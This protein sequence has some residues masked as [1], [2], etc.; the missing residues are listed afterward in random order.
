MSIYKARIFKKHKKA[1]GWLSSMGDMLALMLTF[2]VLLFSISS[3][4]NQ[5]F[6]STQTISDIDEVRKIANQFNYS[7]AINFDRDK[8][9]Q[10]T[11]YIYKVLNQHTKQIPGF[12]NVQISLGKGWINISIYNSLLFHPNGDRLTPAG[13]ILLLDLIDLLDIYDNR[14]E[15]IGNVSTEAP[16]LEN[17]TSRWI[18]GLA[19]ANTIRQYLFDNGVVHN[20]PIGSRAWT[21]Q[22]QVSL[23]FSSEEREQLINRIEF[24]I[25]DVEQ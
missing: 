18:L 9:T 17:I 21:L 19:Y 10:P 12:E 13:K 24:V 2:F 14:I 20:L 15:I 22:D 7:Y 3:L 1:A 5:E 4:V 23:A 11:R 6:I 16:L 25:Y 8:L